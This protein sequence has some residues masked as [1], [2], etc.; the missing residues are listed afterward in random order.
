MLTD[1]F[2]R[3]GLRPGDRVVVHSSLR[4]FG[5]VE[6]GANTVIQALLD[7]VGP[8]GLLVAP[9][10]SYFTVRFDPKVEPGLTGR[11]PETMRTWPGAV[12]S[13]HP[14]HSVVAIG[15]DAEEFCAGHHLVGGLALDSPLDRL[16]KQ[17]GY[18]LL[19]GVG[20]VANST[21]HVGEAHVPVHYL[22]VPFRP[23]LPRHATVLVDGEE[24]A[25]P[26]VDPPGCSRAFGAIER[27][28]RLRGAVVDG[29]VGRAL[30][31]LVRGRDVI[32]TTVALLREDQTALLCSDPLCYRC[33][34]AR[35]WL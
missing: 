7:I 26:I 32:D 3:L 24:I 18:V 5:R 2:H 21:V 20:H 23:D 35:K 29:R 16:A 15:A 9:T 11:I 28:L 17:G 34:E 14:T 10:F 30:S 8:E 27:P 1:D 12:R 31:Q 33:T 6:G 25:V 19:L 4:A 22:D 13:W